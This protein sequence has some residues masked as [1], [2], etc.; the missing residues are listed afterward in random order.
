MYLLWVNMLSKSFNETMAH[1]VEHSL[2]SG[3]YQWKT[4]DKKTHG[5]Y[6][7]AARVAFVCSVL[8]KKAFT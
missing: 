7:L 6:M 2:P 1:F 5:I 3:E 4:D 8:V